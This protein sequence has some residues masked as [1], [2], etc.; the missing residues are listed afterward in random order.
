WMKTRG[1]FDPDFVPDPKHPSKVVISFDFTES[2]H[3]VKRAL[4]RDGIQCEIGVIHGG[5]AAENAA[6]KERFQ[7]FTSPMRVML[8]QSATGR[9]FDLDAADDL[10]FF[11]VPYDPDVTSQ[12][13]DRIDRLSR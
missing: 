2:L 11:D 12:V 3:W 6:D 10:I 13:E 1:Y 8:L 7:D 5:R 9:G 4:E